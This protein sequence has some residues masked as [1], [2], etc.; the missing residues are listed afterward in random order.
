MAHRWARKTRGA[1]IA[2]RCWWLNLQLDHLAWR[3][4]LRGYRRG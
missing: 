2:L 3:I 4:A 1:H